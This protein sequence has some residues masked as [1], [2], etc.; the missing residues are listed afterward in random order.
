MDDGSIMIVAALVVLV[1]LSGFFSASETAY[2]SLNE[3]RMKSRAEDGDAAAARV[4]AMA[5]QRDKLFSTILVGDTI[6]NLAAASLGVL[7]LIRPLGAL[8]G[9]IVSAVALAVV[10]LLFGEIGPRSMAREIP[11]KV[12]TA[13]VPVMRFFIPLL[14]PLTGLFGLWNKLVTHCFHSEAEPDAITEGELITMVSEA[15]SEGE[16]TDREGELIRSA[17]EFDDVE[18]DEILTPRV[19]VVA[20]KD[21][22]SFD[23]LAEVFAESGYSRLPVYHHTIDNIVGVVHEKDASLARLRGQD[24]WQQLITPALFTTGATKISS[25]LR[26]FREEHHH[27]AIVVDEYG[28]TEG[29]VTLE[30]ILEE[31]VGEIWDE[32]DQ[33]VEDFRPQPD[34]SWLVAGTASVGDLYE[35]LDIPPQET[36][37]NTVNGLLQDLTG[38]LPKVGDGFRLGNYNGVVTHAARRR[39]TEVRLTPRPAPPEPAEEEA[40]SGR[41]FSHTAE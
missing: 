2:S 9:T 35:K 38:H 6:A 39:V 25:M 20:V 18:V 33:A 21:S 23:A 7:L 17:I 1:I 29:I 40:P 22:I 31:L 16:L 8:R 41:W 11:E 34:G 37:S 36:D 12:A 4:L 14:S 28:G 24:A 5:Q 10:I 3:I 30:D 13:S 26:T 27:I 15:E 19:D 32:H